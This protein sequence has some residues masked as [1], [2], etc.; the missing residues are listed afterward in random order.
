VN[1][2]KSKQTYGNVKKKVRETPHEN[3]RLVTGITN[4]VIII[5]KII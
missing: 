5:I 4:V 1:R 2:R 3:E